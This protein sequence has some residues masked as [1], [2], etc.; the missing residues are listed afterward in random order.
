MNFLGIDILQLIV[1]GCV[2]ASAIVMVYILKLTRSKNK[3]E[4]AKN[5][6]LVS[7]DII[8]IRQ[9]ITLIDKMYSHQAGLTSDSCATPQPETQ[10]EKKPKPKTTMK[11]PA[12]LSKVNE[13][14]YVST[15]EDNELLNRI[16]E[17]LKEK[18]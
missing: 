9:L 10:T 15:E 4:P 11:S 8:T 14:N 13:E 12:T 6:Q 18:E 1:Y 17:Q 7:E 16:R 3:T 5:D 2:F